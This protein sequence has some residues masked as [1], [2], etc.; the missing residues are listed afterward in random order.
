MLLLT[1]WEEA[2]PKKNEKAIAMNSTKL[3]EVLN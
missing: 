3:E 1:R 2:D